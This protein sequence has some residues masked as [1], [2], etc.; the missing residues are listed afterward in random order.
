MCRHI[1]T[2][3][4]FLFILLLQLQRKKDFAQASQNLERYKSKNNFVGSSKYNYVGNS[5]M[6]NAAKI[7]D[8]YREHQFQCPTLL[9]F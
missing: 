3:I 6:S 4:L 7:Y 8:I 5:S 1:M 2:F 9:F